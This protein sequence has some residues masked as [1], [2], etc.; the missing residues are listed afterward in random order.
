MVTKQVLN[1]KIFLS[2]LAKNERDEERV[3]GEEREFV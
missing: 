1:N 2:D 3:E